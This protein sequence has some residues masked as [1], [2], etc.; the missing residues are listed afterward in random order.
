MTAGVAFT[1][2]GGIVRLGHGS[3]SQAGRKVACVHVYAPTEALKI[4]RRNASAGWRSSVSG[5]KGVPPAVRWVLASGPAEPNAADFVILLTGSV[6]QLRLV[7]V[8]ARGHWIWM[9]NHERLGAAAHT[10]PSPSAW[11][12]NRAR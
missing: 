7:H 9:P 6:G 1:C 10:K 3:V 5:S 11:F 8:A 4:T 2:Y 12:V